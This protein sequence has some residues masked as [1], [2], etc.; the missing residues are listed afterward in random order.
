MVTGKKFL[1]VALL[2]LLLF[3]G[4]TGQEGQSSSMSEAHSESVVSDE[5]SITTDSEKSSEMT[6]SSSEADQSQNL[7]LPW[8]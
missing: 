4:C 6:S 3:A 5:S 8:F 2:S 1:F 7:D